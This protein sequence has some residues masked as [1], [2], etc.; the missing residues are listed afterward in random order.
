MKKIWLSALLIV[1]LMPALAVRAPATSIEFS[2]DIPTIPQ[3]PILSDILDGGAVEGTGILTVTAKITG[4]NQRQA[5]CG[6]N[7]DR[8]DCEIGD[9]YMRPDPDV[10]PNPPCIP[11]PGGPPLPSDYVSACTKNGNPLLYY[12]INDESPETPV[13]MTY[14]P[15]SGLFKGDIPFGALPSGNTVTYYIVASDSRGNVVSQV[16]DKITAPCQSLSTWNTPFETPPLANCSFANGWNLCGR[17]CPGPSLPGKPNCPGT[18][19]PTCGASYTIN[20]PTGDTCDVNQLVVGGK[21]LVDATGISAGAGTG[22]GELP[23]TQ[24]ICTRILLMAPPPSS[25]SGEIDAYLMIFFNP[26]IP[27]PNPA[28]VY[29]TNAFAISYAPEAGGADPNLV[30]VLWDGECVTNPNT[31]DPLSCKIFY[32]S[33]IPELKIGNIAN[34]LRFIAKNDL[35]S[36]RTMIGSSSKKSTMVFLTGAILLSGETPF[37]MVDMTTGL[38][39]VKDN[40]TRTVGPPPVPAPPSVKKTTCKANGAGTTWACPKSASQPANNVC[41]IE[42]LPSLNKSFVAKYK[43]YHNTVDDTTGAIYLGASYDIPETGAASYTK[44]Y[45]VN[46]LDGLTHY[47]YLTS[48]STK[49]PPDET[50]ITDATKTTC[51][52]E[53]WK[54]PVAPKDFTCATPD[55]NEKRCYCAWQPG[56]PVPPDPDPD[57]SLYGYYLRRGSTPLNTSAILGQNFTDTSDVL[58][59]GTPVSYWVKAIDIGDNYSLAETQADCTPEDLKPPDKVSTMSVVRRSSV[60]DVDI[61]WDPNTETD[62]SGYYIYYCP[63][64]GANDL[65]NCETKDGSN[66]GAAYTK[67]NTTII[68]QSEN[69]ESSNHEPAFGTADGYWCF[70]I[71][72]CDDCNTAGTCDKDTPNCSAFSTMIPYRQCMQITA[73]ADPYKP[74]FPGN[75]EATAPAEGKKCKITWDK[76]CS[77]DDPAGGGVFPNPPGCDF[78][79]SIKLQGYKIMRA[80]MVGVDCADTTV[81]TPIDEDYLAGRVIGNS[82]T[83]EFEDTKVSNNVDYCYRVYG[84]D[85]AGA[86]NFSQPPEPTPVHCKPVDTVPPDKPDMV[87]QI[88]FDATSCTPKWATGTEQ[89]LIYN[90]YK[91]EKIVGGVQCNSATQFALLNVPE[92][93]E[94][95]ALPGTVGECEDSD[96]TKDHNYVYCVTAKDASLNESAKYSTPVP[97]AIYPINCGDCAPGDRCAPPTNVQAG[98]TS[99]FFSGNVWFDNAEGDDTGTYAGYRVYLCA[100]ASRDT[101]TTEITT[102]PIT[103]NRQ[104]TP[105]PTDSITVPSEGYYYLGVSFMAASGCS[106]SQITVSA[107]SILIKVDDPCNDN[108]DC[109]YSVS[110]TSSFVKYDLVACTYDPVTCMNGAY[111]KSPT[112]LDEITVELVTGITVVKSKIT[113]L[114][115]KIGDFKLEAGTGEGQLDL[116]KTYVLQARFPAT[117]WTPVMPTPSGIE[118]TCAG[119]NPATDECVRVLKSNI[120]FSVT[121]KEVEA[122]AAEVPSA[123]GGGA[124]VGNPNCDNQVSLSDLVPIKKSFGGVRGVPGPPEY[125]TYADLNMDGKV[126]LGDLVPIKKNFGV[127]FPS[128]TRTL[129][130]VLCKP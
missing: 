111:K 129:G 84:Y 25:S 114:D 77:D 55:G 69:L 120:K 125:Q 1:C 130:A 85:S 4:D 28:D 86:A 76:V 95:S 113:G 32:G 66:G 63:K 94:C 34:S 97:P 119:L 90:V 106:E 44:D 68:P 42:V 31:Q 9:W 10:A 38:Q 124:E 88:P 7:C 20:D 5:C 17:N 49:V 18:L 108:P 6:T 58:V 73:M 45:T 70:Y 12:Y 102:T 82:V 39:L 30:K 116:T 87:D 27:D 11:N 128:P 43:I 91:C 33:D 57:T 103:G 2:F 92:Y 3:C 101:C 62:M 13:Q 22:Y 123:G 60:W 15:D 118:D 54:R 51:R 56:T 110:L 127:T 89:G 8:T 126:D 67:L 104:T 59:N 74:D 72:A 37:W 65:I 64:Q 71:E 47:F 115:G 78:P 99:N 24:V 107:A 112:S 35:G 122:K 105:Y 16:P 96:V 19:N 23:G 21:D 29:M 46:T 109:Q 40:K 36:G 117:K 83:M 75:Q 93:A 26:D 53:D 50:D 98:E 41:S 100:G 61:S 48:L 52:V 80:I 81:P 14:D 121:A 79:D